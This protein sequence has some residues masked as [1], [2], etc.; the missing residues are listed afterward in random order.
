MPSRYRTL[1]GK[2]SKPWHRAR[3]E[4]MRST[5][6]DTPRAQALATPEPLQPAPTSDT[7][8]S[9][10]SSTVNEE[11]EDI[12]DDAVCEFREITGIDLTDQETD[13]YLRIQDCHSHRSVV[14]AIDRVAQDLKAHHHQSDHVGTK[15]RASLRPIVRAMLRAGVFDIGG[16]AAASLS[17][18]GGKAIF[19]AIGVLL[20][21]TEGVPARVDAVSA[22]LRKYKQ[23]VS[24]LD[25]R[26]AGSPLNHASRAL[27]V[28]IF[29]D[30]LRTFAVATKLMRQNRLVQFL[31][32]LAGKGDDVADLSKSTEELL[33]EETRLTLS[34]VHSAISLLSKR[35]CDELDRSDK[36]MRAVSSKVDT[37]SAGIGTISSAVAHVSSGVSLVHTGLAEVTSCLT[38]SGILAVPS[39]FDGHI[40]ETKAK[41]DGLHQTVAAYSN[42]ILAQVSEQTRG[43]YRLD[44]NSFYPL[45]LTVN[46]LG[47]AAFATR[48]VPLDMTSTIPATSVTAFSARV[49]LMYHDI[50]SFTR[51]AGDLISSYNELP[52]EDQV[53]LQRVIAHLYVT[54]A[55]R[56]VGGST[57]NTFEVVILSLIQLDAVVLAFLPLAA[58]YLAVF[59]Y[60]KIFVSGVLRRIPATIGQETFVV[61]DVLGVPLEVPLDMCR[62]WQDL[63]S[64]LVRRFSGQ[65][66]VIST[67]NG[68][69]R[70]HEYRIMSA[71]E[72]SAIIEPHLWE[73]TVR[74]GMVV[75]MSIVMR[76]LSVLLQCPRCHTEVLRPPYDAWVQCALCGGSYRPSKD[77]AHEDLQNR[78]TSDVFLR[79]DQP[80]SQHT[81]QALPRTETSTRG[82]GQVVQ[83]G[84]DSCSARNT[85]RASNHRVASTD[86]DLHNLDLVKRILVF[87][88]IE[89][90]LTPSAR[91]QLYIVF[92]RSPGR[93]TFAW[94]LVPHLEGVPFPGLSP[95]N[96]YE[97]MQ[98]RRGMN[99]ELRWITVVRPRAFHTS[100]GFLGVLALPPCRWS[101]SI[102][103][104]TD[105][106]MRHHEPEPCYLSAEERRRW[107]CPKWI[108]DLLV[109][110]GPGWGMRAVANRAALFF[111]ISAQSVRL[112]NAKFH[113]RVHTDDGYAYPCVQY[114]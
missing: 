17:I 89:R 76:Q 3:N 111:Y 69:V 51:L 18:P 49:S 90:R 79:R 83:W 10:T 32:I 109:E 1:L 14:A 66:G 82:S 16:E 30:M 110:W 112:E 88:S 59:V 53:L 99:A 33:Q 60:W 107:T 52:F 72:G 12:W 74:A 71:D 37:L 84:R 20:K 100:S 54:S 23:Y 81:L 40:E 55:T 108:C 5:P 29:A 50:V 63:H 57:D 34:E 47:R 36:A 95:I 35:F 43:R 94:S 102:G 8:L 97:I 104:V 80:L 4:P 38:T 73:E 62:S 106:L 70:S 75:E 41:I 13:L 91:T 67:I 31:A 103:E 26:M 11:L 19:V 28:A 68:Y 85:T 15:I 105:V 24:R 61:V 44:H 21:A 48:P 78:P 58:I 46:G 86:E 42:K 7:T 22:L 113:E 87:H 39:R 96:H 92:H 27:A 65:T 77:D 2:A 6:R 101:T 98:E 93:R 25:V 64:F 114:L 45:T 56:V 9:A